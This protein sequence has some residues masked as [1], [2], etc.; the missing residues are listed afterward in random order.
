MQRLNVQKQNNMWVT[1]STVTQSRAGRAL[2]IFREGRR[3][4]LMSANPKLSWNW[5]WAGIFSH[6]KTF[7]LGNTFSFSLGRNFD[8][9][10]AGICSLLDC[11]FLVS[12]L[13][14]CCSSCFC[15]FLFFLFFFSFPLLVVLS[16]FF[17]LLPC[18]FHFFGLF[19]LCLLF[20]L[21]LFLS[22][23][24]LS[25]LLFLSSSCRPFFFSS[26]CFR[27]LL[28]FSS[29]CLFSFSSIC[30]Y[31]FFSLSSVPLSVSVFLFIP[32]FLLLSVF[33]CLFSFLSSFLVFLSLFVFYLPLFLVFFCL[34]FLSAAPSSA[35]P[36][37]FS[38]SFVG[39]SLLLLSS[40]L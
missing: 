13:F 4:F 9:V 19:S 8:A 36:F 15:L 31:L 2:L 35:S 24:F 7:W 37:L 14:V 18:S 23:S 29:V 27:V 3:L 1:S 10:T 26:V 38:V 33:F 40:F 25:V 11:T 16:F 17:C 12:F 39:A 30:S 22:I 6:W 20:F 21:F 5:L 32:F 34:L 28:S